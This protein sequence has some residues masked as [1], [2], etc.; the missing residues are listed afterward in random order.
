MNAAYNRK[1]LLYGLPG[2]VVQT[3]G[4]FLPGLSGV[5]SQI[6]GTLLLFVGLAFYAMAEARHPAWCLV[7]FLSLIGFI[8]LACLKDKAPNS[9]ST[10][11]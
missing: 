7:A 9:D 3:A 5:L 11:V 1:S 10:R 2:L 4:V 8:V 6:V